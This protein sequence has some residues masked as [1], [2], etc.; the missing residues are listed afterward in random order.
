MN[1]TFDGLDKNQQNVLKQLAKFTRERGYYLAGGTAV[2]IYLGHRKS[3]DLDWFTSGN[4]GD[5]HTFASQMQEKGIPFSIEQVSAGTLHGVVNGVR[6]SFLEFHYP[7]ITPPLDLQPHNNLI[8]SLHDLACMK[9]SALAQRG[10]RKDF[11]DIYALGM[12]HFSLSEMLE[13][14]RT[15]FGIRDIGHVLYGLSFFDDAE[16]ERMPEM[17]WD[18]EWKGIKRTIQGWVKKL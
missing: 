16:K 13:F 8:C 9:L 11:C 12:K 18:I 14:Y 6:V 2:S 7:F 10:A 17:L 5:A 4:M 15:K 3:V 1:F